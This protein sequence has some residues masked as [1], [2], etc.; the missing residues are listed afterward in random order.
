MKMPDE[1]RVEFWKEDAQTGGFIKSQYD[2]IKRVLEEKDFQWVK[3]R[4]REIKN[5]AIQNTKYYHSYR[6]DDT[7]PVMTK[8]MLIE[9]H[10]LILAKEGFREPIHIS[11]TS[12]STGTPFSVEQDLIKRKRNIADLQVFGELCEYPPREK[13]V[14][15]RVL[16]AK[17][18][19]TPEQEARENIF[20]VDSSRL[21]DEHLEEMYQIIVEKKPR[22]IFSYA[23]TLVALAEYVKNN[24]A[25]AVFPELKSA[26]TAGEAIS[27]DNRQMLANVFGCKA[28]RRY[29]DMELGILGQD[30][31]DGGAYKLNWGSYYFECLKLDSDEPTEDGEVGRIVITDLFN[32]A[33]PMIRYDTGDLGV[34]E[35][36]QNDFPVLKEIHGRIRD[37][38]YST[39]GKII[40]PAK[41]S[42]SMWGVEGV[43]QW[44]FIQNTIDNYTLKL[45]ADSTGDYS[46]IIRIL[47]RILG[48]NAEIIIE[49]VEDIPVLSSNKRRAVICN[50]SKE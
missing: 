6:V 43:K 48:E 37:C 21:D 41:I 7:F 4:L 2:E 28:Y 50:Y 10:S 32:Y 3:A 34:M 30:F 49:F 18:H 46:A 45:N 25:G 26:L 12:G 38:V 23:S 35:Y 1:L 42:V 44:Q 17:L 15:F 5:H 47:K 27:E 24:H 29:S 36:R 40:S 22:I 11:S 31:G 9:Q 39:D 8:S 13:M 19:R 16:S 20:Y 14:F 33:F